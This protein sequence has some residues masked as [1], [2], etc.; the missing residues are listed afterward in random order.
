MSSA[1]EARE[2]VRVESAWN[3][4]CRNA[5]GPS[6]PHCPRKGRVGKE[7]SP[8][9]YGLEVGGRAVRAPAGP[10]F[11]WPFNLDMP[12]PTG[13]TPVPMAGRAY[14]FRRTPLRAKSG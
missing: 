12:F 3:V 13:G 2:E 14:H 1:Q 11:F 8:F 7:T 9:G 10:T 4:G 5:D 6:A